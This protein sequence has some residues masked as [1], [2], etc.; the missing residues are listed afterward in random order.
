M[1]L[2]Y[3]V[4]SLRYGRYSERLPERL[5]E[6]RSD[7]FEEKNSEAVLWRHSWFLQEVTL[8]IYDGSG[9]FVMGLLG[10]RCIGHGSEL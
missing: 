5:G 10:K 6:G 2:I 8:F 9:E 1:M 7:I 3:S 4:T